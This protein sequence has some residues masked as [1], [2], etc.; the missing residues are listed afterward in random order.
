MFEIFIAFRY[1][2]YFSTNCGNVKTKKML[3]RLYVKVLLR[4]TF[5]FNWNCTSE[6][7]FQLLSSF[8]F[9]FAKRRFG[10]SEKLNLI[11][12]SSLFQ[13]DQL[14]GRV[15]RGVSLTQNTRWIWSSHRIDSY[16]APSH[17]SS[18]QWPSPAW[19]FRTCFYA[20]MRFS[21]S[22]NTFRFQFCSKKGEVSI[23]MF[24]IRKMFQ[25]QFFFFE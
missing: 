4:L 14:I 15:Y 1:S 24:K 3:D 25:F 5:C 6:C 21:F 18:V 8:L 16:V 2:K 10:K 22:Q 23:P 17:H 7:K 11:S 20:I 12:F 13:S 19:N 9:Q